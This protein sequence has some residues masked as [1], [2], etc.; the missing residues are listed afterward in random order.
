MPPRREDKKSTSL[1][2]GRRK[3]GRRGSVDQEAVTQNI[4]RTMTTIR[5][6]PTRRGRRPDE[7]GREDLEAIR[8]A[9]AEKEQLTVRVNEF[10]TVSELAD[11][12]KTPATQIVP[13]AFKHLNL[14]VTINQRLDFDQNELKAGEFEFQAV[15]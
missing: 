1:P 4:S 12:L 10:I 8:A 2:G 14:M 13:F 9:E 3:K 7:I 5:G 11:I 15:R 6:A